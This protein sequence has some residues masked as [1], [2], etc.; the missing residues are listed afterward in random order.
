MTDDKPD[1]E[2]DENKP[3]P[4]KGNTMKRPEGFECV[5]SGSLQLT[6]DV[7]Q[8]HASDENLDLPETADRDMVR[9]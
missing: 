3:D 5:E 4:K 9:E 6:R 7:P 8:S 1:A 2:I